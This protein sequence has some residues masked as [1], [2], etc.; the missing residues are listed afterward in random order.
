MDQDDEDA[1]LHQQ[2]LEHEEQL[3]TEYGEHP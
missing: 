3:S 2:E 1:A